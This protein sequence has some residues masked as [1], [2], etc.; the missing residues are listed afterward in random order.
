MMSAGESESE[1][2]ADQLEPEVDVAE[3]PYIQTPEEEF[4][5]VGYLM[6]S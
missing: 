3:T 1:S 5:A 2:D 4:G 6:V